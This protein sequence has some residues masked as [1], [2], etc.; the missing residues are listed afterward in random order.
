MSG[1][2]TWTRPRAG[3]FKAWGPRQAPFPMYKDSAIK[4]IS[5]SWMK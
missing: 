5:I 4:I 1:H 2:L 3:L